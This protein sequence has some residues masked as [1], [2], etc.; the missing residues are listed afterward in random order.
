MQLSTGMSTV[1]AD[2]E[3]YNAL[4]GFPAQPL[5]VC[6]NMKFPLYFITSDT[7]FVI[8]KVTP[9]FSTVAMTC[10]VTV[11]SIS[12]ENPGPKIVRMLVLSSISTAPEVS[13]CD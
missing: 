8:M 12:L 11:E 4:T 1:P 13:F 9:L 7:Y 3:M 10:R 5:P 2:G 6:T